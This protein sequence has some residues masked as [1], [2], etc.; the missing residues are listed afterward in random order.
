VIH[1]E[2]LKLVSLHVHTLSVMLDV[3]GVTDQI[4]ACVKL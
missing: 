3:F 2:L 4:S 1:F